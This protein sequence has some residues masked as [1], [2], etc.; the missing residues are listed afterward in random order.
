MPACILLFRIR[1]LILPLPWFILWLLLAPIVLIG[2]FLGN[3]GLIFDPDN[4][5]LKAA[6][7]SWRLLMLLMSLHGTEVKVDTNAEHI[8]LKFI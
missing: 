4:Y 5:P 8:Q 3:I 6:S 7:E 1:K 2:W